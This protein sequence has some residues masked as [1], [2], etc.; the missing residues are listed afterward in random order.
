MLKYR[1]VSTHYIEGSSLMDY[2]LAAGLTMK[3][4]SRELFELTGI[5]IGIM[6]ISRIEG[7]FEFAA[8]E[9]MLKALLEIFK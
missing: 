1:T 3:E 2:R 8:D 4:L 7:K 5:R 6:Q 9:A